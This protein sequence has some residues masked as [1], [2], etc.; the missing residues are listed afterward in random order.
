MSSIL[1]ETTIIKAL[2]PGGAFLSM[3]GVFCKTAVFKIMV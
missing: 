2:P 3:K 1:V